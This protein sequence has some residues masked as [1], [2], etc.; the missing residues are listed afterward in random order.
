MGLI[1]HIRNDLGKVIRAEELSVINAYRQHEAAYTK[2]NND[3]VE[4]EGYEKFGILISINPLSE[5]KTIYDSEFIINIINAKTKETISEPLT[6]YWLRFLKKFNHET[7][8]SLFVELTEKEVR[9][10]TIALNVVMI[11]QAPIEAINN[12]GSKKLEHLSLPEVRQAYAKGQVNLSDAIRDI[13]DKEKRE[14]LFNLIRVDS[15]EKCS[16]NSIEKNGMKV[17]TSFEKKI[18]ITVTVQL[19]NGSLKQIQE[20]NPDIFLTNLPILQRLNSTDIKY[21]LDFR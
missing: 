14:L 17:I 4:T 12:N 13:M 21:T 1:M 20:Q 2:I 7:C 18:P 11:K 10:D 8:K 5:F 16:T 9:T 3:S 6:L 15:N 19:I